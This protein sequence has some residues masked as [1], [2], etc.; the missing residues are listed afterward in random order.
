MTSFANLK[1]NRNSFEKLS[2]A[3]EATSTGTADSNSKEDTRFWQPEVDKAGNGMAVIRFLPAP[4]I[5]GDDALPW[6]RTFSHG[7]Q[8]PGG[9]FIDN[10]LTTLNEKCP[11]CEH[12]NTLWNSGVE[13]NKDVARKQKRKLSYV[14][15]ILV[16]SDPSNSSNEGQIRLY[17]FGKK[18]FDKITEAMN[19]EFADE[20]PVNPFDLWEGANFKLKIRNVEGYRNYDKS[21]FADASVLL[22]GDDDKLEE[23]WK[24]EYSLKDF[25]ERKNFKPY[26][27]LKTRLEKVLGFDGAPIVKSKAEDTVATLKDDT[28]VLNKPLHADDEDLDYF[29]SL[30]EQE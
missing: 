18:I 13:A 12:N 7:F 11:V 30:A 1:R 5:D 4:S 6:V 26:D 16:I 23:L 14:A 22:N 2:K 27:Q 25:T 3:V 9:W 17:K 19:P 24:K 21:E 28:S 10:C 29:K 20:T 15:N 8:G